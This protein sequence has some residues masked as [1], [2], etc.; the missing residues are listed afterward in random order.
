MSV[1]SKNLWSLKVHLWMHLNNYLNKLTVI[2]WGIEFE[3][4]TTF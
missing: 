3:E 4:K 2:V 1:D